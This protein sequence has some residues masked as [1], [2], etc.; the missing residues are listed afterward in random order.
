MSLREEVVEAL[1]KRSAELL[2]IDAGSLGFETRFKEDIKAKSVDMVKFSALL[3]DMYE[4][5]VP[6]MEFIKKATFGEVADYI[7]G[8]LGE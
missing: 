4:V 6:Y 8:M 3:E 5:E 2:G 1:K 7:A